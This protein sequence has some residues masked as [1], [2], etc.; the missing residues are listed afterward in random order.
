M[1]IKIEKNII[2]LL[3]FL[4]QMTSISKRCKLTDI[5]LCAN[6]VLDDAGIYKDIRGV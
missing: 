2:I 1:Y 6:N 3:Y 5:L 4:W